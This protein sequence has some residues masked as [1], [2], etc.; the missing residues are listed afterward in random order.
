MTCVRLLVGTRKGGFLLESGP[1]REK[2]T[3]NGPFL[4]GWEVAEVVLDTRTTPTMYAAVGHFVYGPTIQVS[5]DFGE[6]WTQAE[7]NP[8]YPETADSEVSRIWTVVPG[9]PEH[10]DVLYA[11]VDEAGIFRSDDGGMT[12]SE[13][14]AL[15]GHETRPDWFP[16][17]GG[18]CCH[19][20]LLD[21]FDTERMWVGISAVGVFR[22][23][24]GGATWTLKNDGLP[25]A[26]PSEEH[27][28]LGS[29]VHSL[30]IDPTDSETL[31][32]QNHQGMYRSTDGAD[33]WEQIQGGLPSTFG[34]P[35]AIHPSHPETLYA[36]PLESDEYRLPIDGQPA[37][38][39][40]RNGG[41]TWVRSSSGLP[42]E[43]WV[44]VL[45]QAM[46]TDPMDPAGVYVGTTGGQIFASADAGETW[47]TVDCR[48]PKILSL[49]ATVVT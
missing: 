29:C 45:R 18:L 46:A 32:Q 17:N 12:W 31:Y 4:K 14:E 11:G 2:W 22:T 34:F 28:T 27:P 41:D 24:D 9:R 23:D 19:T 6:T 21:P 20:V 49:N 47:T 26:A 15:R 42:S 1:D 37:V 25:V 39:R 43:S 3:V 38:Y 30:V 13:L 8:E 10:P 44:T 40:T 5:T 16:G 33:S 48:L 35:L 7:T 36:F